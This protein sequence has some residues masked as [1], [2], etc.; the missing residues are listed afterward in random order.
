MSQSN[1]SE[2]I[3]SIKW[4]KKAENRQKGPLEAFEG[5][6]KKNFG[7]K[8]FQLIKLQLFWE[9]SF[10]LKSIFKKLK[11]FRML[12]GPNL[13]ESAPTGSRARV[14]SVTRQNCEALY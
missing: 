10:S 5:F 7:T 3:L 6:D 9:K 1:P 2:V 8:K 4:R 11:I 13:R 12:L 14:H